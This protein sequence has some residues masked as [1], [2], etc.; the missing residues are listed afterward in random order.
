MSD[1]KSCKNT[2][3]YR[4]TKSLPYLNNMNLYANDDNDDDA[5]KNSL[6][7]IKEDLIKFTKNSKRYHIL[8]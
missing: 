3:V 6:L 5:K 8:R 4:K 2:L 1:R 7:L